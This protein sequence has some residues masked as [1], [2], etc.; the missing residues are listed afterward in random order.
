MR[1]PRRTQLHR[2]SQELSNHQSSTNADALS[3]KKCKVL[4]LTL[5]HTIRF[6]KNNISGFN[7]GI[8][9]TNNPTPFPRLT[10]P[11]TNST[12]TT[13]PQSPSSMPLLVDHQEQVLQF[14]NKAGRQVLWRTLH[15]RK[16]YRIIFRRR[17]TRACQEAHPM[18]LRPQP[19]SL[20]SYISLVYPQILPIQC[21]L[22]SIDT[23][24]AKIVLPGKMT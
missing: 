20:P 3:A 6:I 18:P 2:H 12:T 11:S 17:R 13:S 7:W 15:A 9:W 24:P 10:L 14:D 16:H 21:Q 1:T 4:T 8:F 23:L 5:L 19:V 22:T